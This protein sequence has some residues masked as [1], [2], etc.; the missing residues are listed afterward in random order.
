MDNKPLVSN[1]ANEEQLKE[2]KIKGRMVEVNE[3]NDLLTLL[4]G[5][6]AP[7]FRRFV[8]TLLNPLNKSSAKDSGS[9][10]YFYEG[11]RNV[12]LRIKAMLRAADVKALNSIMNELEES[13]Q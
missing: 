4:N 6:C 9:W 10:T 8:I 11:E 2:A 3:R 7:Q 12:A 5:P 13:F 1:A